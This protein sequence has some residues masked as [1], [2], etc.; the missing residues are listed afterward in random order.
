M[1]LGRKSD[2]VENMVLFDDSFDIVWGK[3]LLSIT[4]REEGD[5]YNLEIRFRLW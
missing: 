4:M 2:V 5:A 1:Q 3:A